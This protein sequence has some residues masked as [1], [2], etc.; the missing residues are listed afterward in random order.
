M[1]TGSIPE[2]VW[3]IRLVEPVGAMVRRAMLRL[4]FFSISAT[5]SGSAS[6][7]RLMNGLS[8]SLSAL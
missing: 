4:P 8:F 3:L 5:I 2:V 6:R 1:K 7:R